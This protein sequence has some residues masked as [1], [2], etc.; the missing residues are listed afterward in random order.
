MTRNHTAC[1]NTNQPASSTLCLQCSGVRLCGVLPVTFK[2]QLRSTYIFQ[3]YFSALGRILVLSIQC[4]LE[5][6]YSERKS[7]KLKG[8]RFFL[9][10]FC[11]KYE[12]LAFQRSP[13]QTRI[14]LMFIKFNTPARET[15]ISLHAQSGSK[16]FFRY[17]LGFVIRSSPRDI[18]STNTTLNLELSKLTLKLTIKQLR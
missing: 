2:P 17:P 1:Q 14:S 8:K 10:F 12:S 11:K 13:Q 6:R 15:W 3:V 18:F 7:S 9:T 5:F 4:T 16:D